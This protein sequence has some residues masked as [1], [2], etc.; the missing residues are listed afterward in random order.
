MTY[1]R[2]RPSQPSGKG[3]HDPDCRL[4]SLLDLKSLH[5]VR[6]AVGVLSFDGVGL[7]DRNGD[8]AQRDC[9][10][11]DLWKVR[12]LVVRRAYDLD[13]PHLGGRDLNPL[14]QDIKVLD[15]LGEAADEGSLTKVRSRGRCA[16]E[17]YPERLETG[18]FC[19]GWGVGGGGYEE[20]SDK[21]TH[22]HTRTHK[23]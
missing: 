22:T 2:S 5:R 10:R 4:W 7:L 20:Q 9:V 3:T 16:R 19:G 8:L 6:I 23:A 11:S 13:R 12:L 18:G 15:A 17:F 14:G 1:T 21:H